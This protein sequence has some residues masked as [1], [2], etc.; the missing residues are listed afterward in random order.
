MAW[1]APT[2]AELRDRVRF[3]RRGAPIDD[4]YG[5][6]HADWIRVGGDRLVRLAPVRGGEQVQAD[7]LAGISAWILDAQADAMIRDVDES[8]RV[9]D[10][11]DPRRTWNVRSSLDLEGR[12]RWRTMNLEKGGADG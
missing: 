5:N 9:V 2:R 7:R 12:D 6:T 8:Y 10:A 1:T 11:R 4:G 3:E